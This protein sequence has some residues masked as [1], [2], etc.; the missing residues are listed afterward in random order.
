MPKSDKLPVPKDVQDAI[1]AQ[2]GDRTIEG[3]PGWLSLK[4]TCDLKVAPDRIAVAA[5]AL[6]DHPELVGELNWHIA[7]IAS[8]RANVANLSDISKSLLERL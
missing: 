4:P 7:A 5:A 8:Y 3:T 2:C 6:R 1:R